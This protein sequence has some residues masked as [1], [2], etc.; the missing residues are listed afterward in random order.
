[1]SIDMTDINLSFT[2]IPADGRFNDLD[3]VGDINC[4]P[5]YSHSKWLNEVFTIIEKECPNFQVC[6]LFV[7][8]YEK[9]KSIWIK[10]STQTAWVQEGDYQQE[11]NE[12]LQKEFPNTEID[13]STADYYDDF[14][15]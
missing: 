12:F 2:P 8:D 3:C 11:L 6:S 15:D 9:D 4:T 7:S 1:M 10:I 14:D 13:I 5:S